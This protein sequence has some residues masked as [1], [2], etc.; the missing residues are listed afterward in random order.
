MRAK[1]HQIAELARV[2][3]QEA[4]V[5]FGKFAAHTVS[6]RK[7][8]ALE[9]LRETKAEKVLVHEVIRHMCENYNLVQ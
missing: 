5:A 1:E 2:R 3:V 8:E 4:T 9:T 6:D 7:T